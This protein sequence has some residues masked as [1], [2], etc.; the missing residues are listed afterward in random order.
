[1]LERWFGFPNVLFTIW[2]PMLLLVAAY[3]FVRGLREGRDRWPFL[4]A[5]AMFVLKLHR[6]R[7][8][9][10]SLHRAAEPDDLAGGRARREPR[11]S[12]SSARWCWC[13]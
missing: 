9:L 1:M 4:A 10:L 5:L 7:H 8:Q 3:V 2:V 11:G 13:R 6:A 12:C